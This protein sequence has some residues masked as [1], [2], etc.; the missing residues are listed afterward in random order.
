MFM[1]FGAYTSK[2]YAWDCIV[3]VEIIRKHFRLIYFEQSRCFRR[4][5]A[6]TMSTY[7]NV[8]HA[9]GEWY[10]EL[11]PDCKAICILFHR[12]HPNTGITDLMTPM[13]CEILCSRR[14]GAGVYQ[15]AGRVYRIK[16]WYN[17]YYLSVLSSP[18]YRHYH[19]P[20]KCLF[21]KPLWCW[22]KQNAAV[23]PE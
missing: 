8:S 23:H 15:D 9:D 17:Q 1:R 4:I 12:L 18:Y 22:I 6:L 13:F 3:E 20:R 21:M 5:H 11:Q 14:R 2:N 10:Q 19:H 7:Y 16:L